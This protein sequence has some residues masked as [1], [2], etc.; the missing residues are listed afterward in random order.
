MLFLGVHGPELHGTDGAVGVGA[1]NLHS[2]QLMLDQRRLIVEELIAGT[3]QDRLVRRYLE[4]LLRATD[5]GCLGYGSDRGTAD[6]HLG[7][8]L[9]RKPVSVRRW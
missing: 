5:R 4:L 9:T 2:P 6:R 8:R 7:Q 3:A 1:S